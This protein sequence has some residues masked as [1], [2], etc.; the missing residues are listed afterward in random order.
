MKTLFLILIGICVATSAE[1]I[2]KR[3][4][5]PDD[6]TN[7]TL[8]V[9]VKILGSREL[10]PPPGVKKDDWEAI[11]YRELSRAKVTDCAKGGRK[12]EVLE[13]EHNNGL[14]CPN[15]VYCE[16]WDCIVFLRKLPN[17]HYETMN[18]Y[19]GCFP[20]G[21]NGLV[22]SC[23]LFPQGSKLAKNADPAAIIAQLRNIAE[24]KR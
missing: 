24:K 7:A 1:A 20:V 2:G 11:Y 4:S 21:E 5:M 13:I 9:R 14:E 15:I 17:G 16:G 23:Y 6:V 19:C 22:D 8:I 10:P 18:T 3:L 12:G